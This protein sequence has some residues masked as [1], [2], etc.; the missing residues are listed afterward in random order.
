MHLAFVM[1]A[2]EDKKLAESCPTGFI[3]HV[4]PFDKKIG[5]RFGFSR[6]P[7]AEFAKA[8][9]YEHVMPALCN[10]DYPAMEAIHAGL[11][12]KGNCVEGNYCDYWIVGSK[13][14]YLKEHPEIVDEKG[15]RRNPK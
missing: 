3:T 9:G 1:T 7:V 11:I 5:N 10:S 12:R 2:K 13:S 6:C 8:H 4:E 14:P 15:Y